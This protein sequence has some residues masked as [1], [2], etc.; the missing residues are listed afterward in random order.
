SGN[1]NRQAGVASFS[2]AAYLD[3]EVQSWTWN[4]QIT[5]PLIRWANWVGYAQADAMTRQ[6]SEQFAL[7][8]QD[9]IL[10]VAQAYLDVLVA[11]QSSQVA[12]AQVQAVAEQLALAQ[13]TYSVGTGTITDVHEARAKWALSQ[14][15]SVAA[16]N[17]L[18]NKQAEL[19][20]ILGEP[21]SVAAM[22]LDK[23]LN[24][25]LPSLALQQI[26]EWLAGA[27]NHNPQVKIQQAAL[28]VARKEVRKSEAAH[29][30]TLDLVL[31]RSGSYNSGTLSSPADI[32][33][34]AYSNQAGLQ[35]NFPLFSGGATQSRVREALAL[36]D[37]AQDEL[38][39]AIRNAASQVRQ[40][41][42]GVVNGQ[43]Q[44]TALQVAVD[45]GKNAV[46]S[47]KIGFRI[48]TR[49]NPD[50][51]NAEVQLYSTLRDLSKARMEIAMQGLKLKAA[52]GALTQEDLAA[53][54]R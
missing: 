10:R 21:M 20:K 12:V 17:E 22:D 1:K 30:P 32:S 14:A 46:E 52:A 29:F 5:Q 45:A 40:A 15:Q 43:A 27:T 13:R 24:K 47:N 23:A 35:L 49:I 16:I 3:R 31:S 7:A 28:E 8:E 53:L 25:G 41:F 51:L 44:V 33:T 26:D 18:A 2:D 50:V 4:A 37:K 54:D 36:E 39:L 19:E 34:L 38:T 48:G 11:D 6:A 9:L 42:A